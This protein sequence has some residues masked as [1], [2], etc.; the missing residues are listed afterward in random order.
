[1]VDRRVVTDRSAAVSAGL[2][3]W[4]DGTFGVVVRRGEAVT[5]S[6]NGPHLAV[7]STRTEDLRQ[8]DRR[9]SWPFG[10]LRT[11][12][13]PVNGLD[14]SI[15][16]AS[17][18]PALYDPESDRIA[19]VY[20][21]EQHLDGD[22]TAYR[23]H[24]GLA[25]T[26]DCGLTFDDHGTILSS[27]VDEDAWREIGGYVEVGPGSFVVHGDR[28]LVFFQDKSLIGRTNLGVATTPLHAAM[29]AISDG[30]PWKLEKHV[31]PPGRSTGHTQGSTELLPVTSPRHC[32]EWFDVASIT[33]DGHLLLVYSS[34]YDHRWC[35][36]MISS[37]D[38]VHWSEP[39]PLLETWSRVET[40]YLTVWS[41][42]PAHQRQVDGKSFDIVCLRSHTGGFDRW[43]HAF[44]EVLTVELT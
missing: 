43:S 27:W 25:T 42:D 36:H 22:P 38:G 35:L 30:T 20:H 16:H 5:L 24:L 32:I 34:A 1:M 33:E 11:S 7:H 17:G 8:V 10:R 2:G 3:H 9:R 28:L 14:P 18:G 39:F 44:L 19:V 29:D 13:A 6:P 37:T 31:G 23:S 26:P 15:V 40:L 12:R 21:A 4:I 41:G